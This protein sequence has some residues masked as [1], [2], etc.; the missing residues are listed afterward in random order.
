MRIVLK[1]GCFAEI[2]F[3]L[4][5]N[6]FENVT[7]RPMVSVLEIDVGNIEGGIHRARNWVVYLNLMTKKITHLK[8]YSNTSLSDLLH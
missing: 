3:E 8:G 4:F 5:G 1:A 2:I 7:N 6:S